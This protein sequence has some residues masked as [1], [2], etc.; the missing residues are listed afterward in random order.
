M[1]SE[2]Q[3]FRKKL[4]HNFL[5]KSYIKKK[6]NKYLK[7]CLSEKNNKYLKRC[8][9]EKNNKYLKRCLS[10]NFLEKI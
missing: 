6:N 9:S 2:M 1:L 7:R 3:L 10:N 5:E 8:L 4:C